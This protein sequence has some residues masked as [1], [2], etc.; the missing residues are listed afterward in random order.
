[1]PENSAHFI[2]T[3]IWLYALLNTGE[4]EK[5]QA[6]QTLIKLSE[7]IV[8]PQVIG[9]VCANLV[10]KAKMPEHEIRKFVEG[11]YAKHCV[12]ELDMRV[13]LFASELREEYSL[14]FWDSLIVSA[15]FLSGAEVIYSEDMQ[16]GLLIRETVK[17]V[18]PIK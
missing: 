12:V 1:M 10:K 15:A 9:E 16:D 4:E 8:S 3:N 14:S 6:A 5:S 17:I 13:F 2:D 7:A 18:N 11:I